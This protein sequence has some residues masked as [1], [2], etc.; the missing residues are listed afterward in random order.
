MHT[1]I[2]L[3]VGNFLVMYYACTFLNY[4][5]YLAAQP[6]IAVLEASQGLTQVDPTCLVSSKR[7]DLFSPC[8]YL[9]ATF[10]N[11]INHFCLRCWNP[12]PT[13]C[14]KLMNLVSALKYYLL[15]WRNSKYSLTVFL[16]SSGSSYI[17]FFMVR[18][19]GFGS[20]RIASICR[21]LVMWICR[22]R[23]LSSL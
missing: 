19:I 21:D 11:Y 14:T 1:E 12:R 22:W 15:A 20:G 17:F 9:W 3:L 5:R 8:S 6:Y 7:V 16:Y 4:F 23:Q 13:S 18:T 10:Q 2:Q